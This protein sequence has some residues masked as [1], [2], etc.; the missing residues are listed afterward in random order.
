[1][2]QLVR[3]V[4]LSRLS[5]VG[6]RL[7]AVGCRLSAALLERSIPFRPADS[8]LRSTTR[9]NCRMYTLLPHDDSLLAVPKHVEV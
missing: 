2:R 5:A 3:V 8:R 9:T 7:S 6:C 1:M 4:C